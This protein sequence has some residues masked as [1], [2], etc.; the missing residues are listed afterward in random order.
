VKNKHDRSADDASTN[1]AGEAVREWH[2]TG[3][4]LTEANSDGW[5]FMDKSNN[6][7]VRVSGDVT[8]EQE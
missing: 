8:V 4:V 2:S 1:G 3:K 5:Y 7:L 6:K